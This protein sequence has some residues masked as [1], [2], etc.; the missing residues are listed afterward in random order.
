MKFKDLFFCLLR[1]EICGTKIDFNSDINYDAEMLYKLSKAHDLA[2]LIGDALSR[3]NI[4]PKDDKWAEK[5]KEEQR[6]AVYREMQMSSVI[7]IIRGLFQENRIKFMLLKGA[8]MR[9]FYPETWQR[10]SCDIDVLVKEEDLSKA[11]SVLVDA[12]FTTDGLKEYHDVSLY[13]GNVHLELHY[14]V[15]ES[16][17]TMDRLLAKIWDYTIEVGGFECKE[18]PEYF[19]FHHI[20][21]MSYHCMTGGCGVRPFIDLFIL[22]NKCFYDEQKLIRLLQTCGL[23]RF[24]NGILELIGVWFNDNKH[25]EMSAVVEKYI[26][27][28]GAYGCPKNSHKLKTAHNKSK[29]LYILRLIFLPYKNMCAAYPIL[30]KHKLLLPFCYIHRLFSKLFGRKSKRAKKNL[31]NIL[32][33]DKTT[34]DAADK[35]LT[36][37][38]L[39]TEKI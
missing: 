2:H 7:E 34:I 37:L 30:Y 16:I 21:H 22:R 4:L 36:Y 15:M 38:G 14:N 12:G 6:L 29:I 24:Y 8:V 13:Y 25:S 5:F 31:H 9:N 18:T 33:N 39:P 17:P 27:S 32:S 35:I 28:G 1:N 11:V 20:A 26:L 10:T 3:N 19:V 23:L